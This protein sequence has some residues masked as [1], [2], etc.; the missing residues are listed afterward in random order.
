MPSASDRAGLFRKSPCG[1]SLSFPCVLLSLL[2]GLPAAHCFFASLPHLAI[3][4]RRPFWSHASGWAIKYTVLAQET[5]PHKPT[6]PILPRSGYRHEGWQGRRT[7]TSEHTEWK[8]KLRYCTSPA[9][10]KPDGT[11]PKGRWPWSN[12]VWLSDL[13]KCSEPPVT[14]KWSPR[15]SQK[16]HQQVGCAGSRWLKR[17]A[18]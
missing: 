15:A 4:A 6:P 10:K 9:D 3:I 12:S 7:L 11:E 16:R 1:A 8:S 17:G 14:E 2:P 5:P 18:F 13:W